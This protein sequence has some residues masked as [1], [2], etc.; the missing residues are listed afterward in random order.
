MKMKC[1]YRLRVLM[2]R[3]RRLEAVDSI[4]VYTMDR[5]PR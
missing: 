2:I 3:W 5:F 4:G 1:S